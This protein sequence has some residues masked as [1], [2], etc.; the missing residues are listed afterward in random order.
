MVHQ[1]CTTVDEVILNFSDHGIT[2]NIIAIFLLAV[3]S[4]SIV[5]LYLFLFQ[6][7]MIYFPKRDISST[8][9]MW[10]LPYESILFETVDGKKLNGWYIPAENSRGTI[11]FC[12][13]NAGNIS[14]R[15]DSIVLFN[16]LALS[17]FI[18]DYRGYGLSEG[19]PNEKGTYRDVEAAWKYM[20]EDRK[21]NASEIILFGRSLGGAIASYLATIQN[22]GALV[23]E[24]SF[25]DIRDL[26]RELYPYLPVKMLSRYRYRTI[27][28]VKN[29]DCPILI[30][31]SLYDEMISIEHGN[32]IFEAAHEPK[33]FLEIRGSHN[34]GFL[35]SGKEY[36]T[37][38]SSFIDKYIH[39]EKL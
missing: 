25:T 22:P 15:M 27:D 32:K 26:G 31:H 38:W 19:K 34:D 5:I 36:E 11:L 39:K 1:C 9:D 18:F 35:L 30:I 17:V 6:S 12:H 13:G 29:I 33:E 7:R 23:I 14:N 37:V 20:V 16:R 21:E 8:P 4:F 24:S 3:G 28:Y 10:N 2:G